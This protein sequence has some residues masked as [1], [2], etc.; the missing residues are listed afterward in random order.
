MKINKTSGME[1]F[2]P[3]IT[4]KGKEVYALLFKKGICVCLSI[5]LRLE[6]WLAIQPCNHNGEKRNSFDLSVLLQCPSHL[7]FPRKFE[8]WFVLDN[9]RCKAKQPSEP[10]ILYV[11]ILMVKDFSAGY[12]HTGREGISQLCPSNNKYNANSKRNSCGQSSPPNAVS[13]VSRQ[14]I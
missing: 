1:E 6:I 8:G 10:I 11:P 13:K 3:G 5:I 4:Q 14:G 9:T 12:A 7:A 2:Y